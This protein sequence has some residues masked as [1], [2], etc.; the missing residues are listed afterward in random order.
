[1]L[2]SG[3]LCLDHMEQVVAR[4]C[5]TRWHFLFPFAIFNLLNLLV[6]YAAIPVKGTARGKPD[7]RQLC[8]L[9][10][11]V[12]LAII[13]GELSERPWVHRWWNQVIGFMHR[14]S[15]HWAVPDDSIHAKI[16]RDNT[17]DA[18][19]HPS[20]DNMGCWHCQATSAACASGD[21]S[22]PH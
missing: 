8:R 14:L 20:C 6:I 12:T 21:V 22:S 15:N 3:K 4:P 2:I 1:M 13:C 7:I 10:K 19:Q 16:L 9:K 18:Q 17:A 5:V 11:S